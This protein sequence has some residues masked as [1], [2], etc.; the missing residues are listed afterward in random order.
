[1]EQGKQGMV[2]AKLMPEKNPLQQIQARFKELETG[3]RAWLAKQSLPV[4]VALVTVTSSAQGAAIGALMGTLTNDM[5]SSL[6]NPPPQANPQ[7]MASFKQAQVGVTLFP[8]S[9][10]PSLLFCFLISE[11]YLF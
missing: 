6:P 1:M 11:T 8:F 2:V 3:F 10:S 5:S 4:E 9:Q 7:A